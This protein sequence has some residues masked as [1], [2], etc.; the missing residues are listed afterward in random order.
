MERCW[1][2]SHSPSG[3]DIQRSDWYNYSGEYLIVH[4]RS[5]VQYVLEHRSSA[6]FRGVKKRKGSANTRS[7][8]PEDSW[9]YRHWYPPPY[10]SWD[11][12]L[13]QNWLQGRFLTWRYTLLK[14]CLFFWCILEPVVDRFILKQLF[15]TIFKLQ[16]N[17]FL[18][19]SKSPPHSSVQWSHFCP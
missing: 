1:F 13:Q 2:L 10:G 18:T 5:A 8:K 19:M 7:R 17:S 12:C 16:I 3:N 11:S 6:F 9:E 4:G 15:K 14:S